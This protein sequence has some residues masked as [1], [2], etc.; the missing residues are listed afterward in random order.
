MCPL[1]VFV[2]GDV[3]YPVQAVLD[4]PVLTHPGHDRGRAGV[5]ERQAADGIDHL[6]AA[7]VGGGDQAFTSDPDDLFCVGEAD[8]SCSGDDLQGA[9]LDTAVAAGVVGSGCGQST[10]PPKHCWGAR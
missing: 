6:H 9:G 2:E 1:T 3:A 7:L 5:L 10:P 4:S 8:S